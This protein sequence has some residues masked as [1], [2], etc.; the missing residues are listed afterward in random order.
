MIQ[1]LNV[2]FYDIYPTCA[3]PFSCWEAG[4]ATTTGSTPGAP[5]QP[6]AG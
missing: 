1:Y 4:C 2:F 5:H 3:A 6:D